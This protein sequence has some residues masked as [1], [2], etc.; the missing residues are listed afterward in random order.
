MRKIKTKNTDEGIITN[1]GII[2]DG[3]IA[4]S[5]GLELNS[6][7][8]LFIKALIAFAASSCTISILSEYIGIDSIALIPCLFTTLSF[9]AFKSKYSLFKIAGAGYLIFQISYFIITFNDIINGF[10]VGL[11]RYMQKAKISDSEIRS[12]V[13]KMTNYEQDHA[14][15]RTMIFLAVIVSVLVALACIVR[16]DFAILFVATFPFMEIGLYHGWDPP[17]VQAV[18]LVSCWITVIAVALINHSTNKAGRNNTFA[19]HRRKKGYYFTSNELKSRF[20]TSYTS[21]VAII[22]CAVFVIVM[23]FSFVTGFVR[24]KSFKTLRHNI[25]EAVEN[26]SFS[27]LQNLLADYDGG[28]DLFAIKSVGGTNGG[29]LGR[30]DGISFDGSTSLDVKIAS[31]PEY[32]L[33]LRGYVAGKYDDNC[34][35]PI[36]K[37]PGKEITD[38]FDSLNIPIQNFDH[39]VYGYIFPEELLGKNDYNNIVSVAVIGAS[40]RFAYAPYNADYTSDLNK[41]SEQMQPTEEGYVKLKSKK[42][43]LK[44]IDMT[45]GAPELLTSIYK[46][47]S[48]SD[49][50]NLLNRYYSPFVYDNYLDVPDL[51][52]LKAAYQE[53]LDYNSG[54]E[55]DNAALAAQAIINYF[56][57]NGYTYDL[58][59]GKT[60]SGKD[61]IDDFMEKKKGYC[62]YYAT[63]GTMLMRMFGYPARYIEGYVVT[64]GEFVRDDAT[65][66]ANVTDKAAHAWCEVFI[67]GAGWYPLEFTPGYVGNGNP[68]M[69]PDEL[70]QNNEIPN[71]PT[72]SLSTTTTT[73]T[74]TVNTSASNSVSTSSLEQTSKQ[75]TTKKSVTEDNNGSGTGNGSGGSADTEDE[76]MSLT[77]KVILADI[78]LTVFLILVFLLN[79]YMRLHKK[80][81]QIAYKDRNKAIKYIYVYYLKYLSLI[82]ISDETNITD[83]HQAMNLIVKCRKLEL[84][85]LI[86]DLS[87]LSE[88]AIEAQ[89]SSNQLSE[90]DYQFSLKALNRLSDEVVLNKLS[91]LGKAT[92][93][94]I[95][96]L[97]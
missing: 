67:D 10:Y 13:Y 96:G 71:H 20:F 4:V 95:F 22:C 94:W 18:V 11:H 83:E 81:R 92:A 73:T 41:K 40:R 63:A 90:D 5:T 31:L 2:I 7:F 34:W 93:K 15:I 82:N 27:S 97:Y 19:V 16:F 28:F 30:K 72:Q 68:N 38:V 66:K 89:H 70:N 29:R 17:P 48:R 64:P 1:N 14:L 76:E 47:S 52:S 78:A 25:T 54:A 77:A 39:K 42:Y 80:N 53:I 55:F 85:S 6:D 79:R 57:R 50:Y 65:Y 23:L 84:E 59:P 58:N 26:F 69:T 60:K 33:Y 56:S 21:F 32:T 35:D 49:K 46:I 51:T 44:Y 87:N 9:A 91:A 88:L 12:V 24:P 8:L 45:F 61:F 74:T 43:Q 3:D 62:S 75:T 86:P 36:D 37:E